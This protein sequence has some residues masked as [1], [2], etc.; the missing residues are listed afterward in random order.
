VCAT[1]V[2]SPVGIP[3]QQAPS[4]AI[5]WESIAV[6][7]V[8]G[9]A[10]QTLFESLF[11]PSRFFGK[12][13]SGHRPLLPF[14]YALM[15][16]SAGSVLGFLWTYLFFSWFPASA[17]LSWLAGPL[18]NTSASSAGLI[19]LPFFIS[20][21]V[22]FASAYFHTLLVLTRSSRQGL[23]STFS[24]VCY[25]ESAEIFNLIPVVGSVVSVVWSLVLITAGFCSVHRMST[26]RA[27]VIIFLPLLILGFFSILAVALV[28]GAAA[29]FSGSL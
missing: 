12:L 8:V 14:V 22:V 26:S 21:K 11:Y 2:L 10:A 25:A 28:A 3:V 13:S 16:G 5:P 6:L 17:S 19:A 29:I 1:P 23:K 24:I 4:S 9:A 20:I 15:V 18:G 7:G 27:L